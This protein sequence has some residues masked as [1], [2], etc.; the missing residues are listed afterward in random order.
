[1]RTNSTLT[2]IAVISRPCD[3]ASARKNGATPGVS[4]GRVSDGAESTRDLV[5]LVLGWVHGMH[6]DVCDVIEPWEHGT[7]L[8]ATRYPSYHDY[9]LVR[10]EDDPGM[11]V[12]ELAAFADEKLAGLAHRRIDFD[13]ANDADVVRSEFTAKGWR[14]TR[15][16]WLHHD[17]SARS[18]QRMPAERMPY[19]D[20]INLRQSWMQEEPDISSRDDTEHFGHAREVALSRGAEVL[21]LHDAGVPIAFTQIEWTGGAAEVSLLYVL[22]EHRGRGLGT[23]LVLAGLGAVR[24]ARDVWICADD[25]D[26][27]KELYKRLGFEPVMTTLEFLR[28]V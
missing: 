2:N 6:T 3:G 16:I 21:A 26:R 18:G 11:S 20:V 25:E 15:L 14:S 22:P 1:M 10:V 17:G 28:M 4:L 24:G 19:D 5:P 8:R 23:S 27:P 12:D 7:V 9:N 13:F